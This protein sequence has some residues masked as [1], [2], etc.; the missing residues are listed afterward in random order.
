[1]KESQRSIRAEYA[2]KEQQ[3]RED[4][5]KGIAELSIEEFMRIKKVKPE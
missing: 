4:R 1:M 5:D 3:M 2:K